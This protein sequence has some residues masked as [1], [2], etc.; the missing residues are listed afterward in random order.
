MTT[1]TTTPSSSAPLS[2]SNHKH[3]VW[4]RCISKADV[5]PSSLGAIRAR[6]EA[7]RPGWRDHSAASVVPIEQAVL[8]PLYLRLKVNESLALELLGPSEEYEQ[9]STPIGEFDAALC[10]LSV[11]QLLSRLHAQGVVHGH[12][13]AG[14]VWRH[15]EDALRFVVT[16]C[17]LPMSALV[18]HGVVGNAARQCAAPEI[19][20]GQPYGGASDVWG[21]GVLLLQLLLGSSKSICTDDL[22]DSDLLS[23]LFST[24]GPSATSFV[25]PCLK[26]DPQTRPLLLQVLRHPFFVSVLSTGSNEQSSD[27]G[28]ASASASSRSSESEYL[29]ESD[30]DST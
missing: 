15:R 12:L 1:T 17:E 11:A 14:V 4:S 30:S 26:S 28:S 27:S 7:L 8:S 21:L 16:E 24:L 13:H 18:P 19:L 20:R 5:Y 23:P 22:A 3:G 29:E 6:V 9:Y 2:S 25:L 10:V